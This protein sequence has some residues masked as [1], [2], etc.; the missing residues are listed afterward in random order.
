LID[1]TTV[2][3]AVANAPFPLTPSAATDA[4]FYRAAAERLLV[5]QTMGFTVASTVAELL[6]AVAD[7]LIASPDTPVAAG[8]QLG[9][10][11]LEAPC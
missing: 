7:A 3:V 6:N 10:A 2:T 5:G 4:S 1:R 8:T 11:E 9:D